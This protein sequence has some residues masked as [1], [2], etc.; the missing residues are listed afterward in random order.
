MRPDIIE[1]PPISKNPGDDMN[2]SFKTSL[3]ERKPLL[4]VLISL[5]SPEI[6]EIYADA[7]FDWLFL[8]W[9]HGLHDVLGLQRIVMAVGEKCPCVIR[10]PDNDP[11]WIAK[12]L[13]TGAAGLIIPH[14]NTAADAARAASAAKYPPLGVRSIGVARAQGYG[15]DVRASLDR[16]NRDTVLIAQAEHIEAAR[17][18]E[19][20]LAVPGVD[21]AFIGPFDLSGSLKKPGQI[22][23]PEVQEAIERIRTACA[24]KRIPVGIFTADLEAAAKYR[25]A[26]FSLLC[27]GT[28]TIHAG[29]AA[30]RIAAALKA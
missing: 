2:D 10:V 27:V 9:E 12:A 30:R 18:I 17:N 19:A 5:P 24:E 20:I 16:D 14:V 13:D 1:N 21:A 4:G 22:G 3:K 11:V 29:Q 23:D 28:D 8:D 25:D 6:A 7:G 15:H 26:G